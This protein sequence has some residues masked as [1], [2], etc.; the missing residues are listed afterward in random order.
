[1]LR[2][3]ELQNAQAAYY[4]NIQTCSIVNVSK[5]PGTW[6]GDRTING[7]VKQFDGYALLIWNY[8]SHG[9]CDYNLHID[10]VQGKIQA[11]FSSPEEI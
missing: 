6:S 1:M 11:M 2:S 10:E 8:S 7:I 3:D 4:D 5:E 9:G